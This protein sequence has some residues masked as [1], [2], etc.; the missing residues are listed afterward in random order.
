MI[1]PWP[2]RARL[3]LGLASIVSAIGMGGYLKWMKSVSD[4]S[5][6]GK[7]QVVDGGWWMVANE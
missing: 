6:L 5:Y 3:L 2:L 4:D 1:R 7:K